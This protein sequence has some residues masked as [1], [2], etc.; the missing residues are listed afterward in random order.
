MTSS[1]GS[2]LS[3]TPLISRA[4]VQ[5]VVRSARLTLSSCCSVCSQRLLKGPSPEMCISSTAWR[6]YSSSL[7]ASDARL[8]GILASAIVLP[9]SLS[10]ESGHNLHHRHRQPGPAEPAPPEPGGG[11]AGPPLAAGPP[12]GACVGGVEGF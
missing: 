9:P 2:R 7:P 6:M 10:S 11:S 5:D 1:P 4:S 8:N 3:R 12:D